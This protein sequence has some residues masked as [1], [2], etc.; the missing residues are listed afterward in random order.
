MEKTP[1]EH[2][3]L[4]NTTMKIAYTAIGKVFCPVLKKEVVFN[5]K[6]FHHLHYKPSGT[7]RTVSER[8]HKLTLIPLAAAVIKNTTTIH[9][10]RNILIPKDRKMGSKMVKAKQYA[11]VSKVGRKKPVEVRVIIL[12]A[13]NSQ[14]PIF[15]SIMKH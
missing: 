5:A 14:H 6:G 9:E 10:E 13:E 15:W 11:L 4:L 8:I 7:P 1:Q 2:F 3:E 12:E